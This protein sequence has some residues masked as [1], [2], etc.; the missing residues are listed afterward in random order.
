LT[1]SGNLSAGRASVYTRSGTTWT[2]SQSFTANDAQ[3]NDKYGS[4]VALNNNYLFIGAP[5]KSSAAFTNE[6]IVY[7]YKYETGG[8]NPY[9]Y[10]RT[11]K[12]INGQSSL[13]FGQ[14]V[15][16]DAILNSYI[17]GSPGKKLNSG[18]VSFGLME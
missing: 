8:V 13:D 10:N 2:H 7:T 14:S 3:A 17:I 9:S 11:I 1:V 18:Q 6:G 16:I 15:A 5:E 12:D 4:A